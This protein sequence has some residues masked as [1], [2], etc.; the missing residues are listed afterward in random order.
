MKDKHSLRAAVTANTLAAV[1]YGGVKAYES[2]YGKSSKRDG[3]K[4]RADAKASAEEEREDTDRSPDDDG[5]C[6]PHP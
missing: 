5:N 2:P 1:S 3:N 4:L 6:L